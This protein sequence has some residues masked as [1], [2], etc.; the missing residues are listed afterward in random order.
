MVSRNCFLNILLS[1]NRYKI[2]KKRG[3]DGQTNDLIKRMQLA[4]AQYQRA[5]RALRTMTSQWSRTIFPA[6]N[7]EVD[8]TFIIMCTF[9]FGIDFDTC[10]IDIYFFFHFFIEKL[11]LYILARAILNFHIDQIFKLILHACRTYS[12]YEYG[13]NKRNDILN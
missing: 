12:K 5:M 2:W 1:K 7:A 11:Y 13:G 10:F 3:G 8:Q 9:Y 6:I 4:G